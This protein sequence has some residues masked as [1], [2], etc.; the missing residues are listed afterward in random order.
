MVAYTS[1]QPIRRWRRAPSRR[2]GHIRLIDVDDRF[3]LDLPALSRQIAAD[4]A[5]GLT[6]AFGAPRS[7]RPV[8]QR[9][10]LSVGSPSSP[11]PTVCGA[12][13]MRPAQGGDALRELRHHVD[14]VDLVDSYTWNAHKWLAT[15]F[16][17]SILWVADRRPLV[18][19]MRIVPPYLQNAAS[20][21]G[22]VI[23]YRDWQVPLGRRFR[24]LKLWFV[25]RAF[26]ADGLRARI[27][28]DIARARRLADWIDDQPQLM[29]IAPT[30]FGLVSFIHVDGDAATDALIDHVNADPG[31]YVLGSAIGGRRFIRVSIGSTW[32]EDRHVDALRD[33]IAAGLG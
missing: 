21:A 26:G 25:L 5:A 22:E 20:D 10:T 4:E 12:T 33:R 7:A 19:A 8:P 23:D 27:R 14:G 31:L 1:A 18:D 29:T 13:S 16:D 30:E 9:S 32:T 6:S 2:V 28:A 17:C 15:N 24:A 3:A 11:G